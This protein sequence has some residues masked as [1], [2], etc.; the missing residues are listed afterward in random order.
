MVQTLKILC[1]LIKKKKI[2]NQLVETTTE[3]K[4]VYGVG[5]REIWNTN[6]VFEKFNVACLLA[7]SAVKF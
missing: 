3:W 5:G 4:T 7:E 6:I 1:I 2:Q